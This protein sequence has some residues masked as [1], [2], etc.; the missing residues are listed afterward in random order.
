[1]HLS[2]H[3]WMRPEPLEVTLK[4]ASS[5]GYK[6]IELAGEPDRYIVEET[7]ALLKKYNLTCWGT[8][9]PM[10]GQRDLVAVDLANRDDT[11]RYMKRVIDLSHGLGGE[12][13]TVVPSTV[14][15]LQPGTNPQQ[16]WGWL[17]QGM[18]EVAL[19]A[20][21][22]NIRIAVEPL[23]RF[24]TYLIT[25]TRQA[26]HLIEEL[27]MEN[28]GV[29]F[30]TFHASIEEPD[31]V[32]AIRNCGSR[33]FDFHLGDNNRL[34]PGDG[35]LNWPLIVQALRDVGYEG[36]LAHEAVPPIDRTSYG[37]FGS[38]QMEAE[39]WDVDEGTLQFLKDHASGVLRDDYYT[40][41]LKRTAETILPLI[42]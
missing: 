11:I 28:V 27:G 40:G 36:H 8:V 10:Y 33:I 19:Y 17:L 20:Q 29:A 32:A 3:T 14:G 23:N 1:M 7:R 38:N 24:E 41:L 2:T 16:E 30:D 21:V 37:A 26:L 42:Q 31:V 13:V 18:R 5:L 12:I 34:S 35:S 25:N 22:K 9:T 4:R 15:K 6:S 39:P